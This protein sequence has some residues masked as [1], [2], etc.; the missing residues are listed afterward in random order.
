MSAY[1]KFESHDDVV[2]DH[3]LKKPFT[4][5]ELG[6]SVNAVLNKNTLIGLNGPIA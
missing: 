3:F 5:Q 6:Q 1:S 4:T 2:V